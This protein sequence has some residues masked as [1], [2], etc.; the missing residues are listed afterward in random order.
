MALD[1]GNIAEQIE[2]D[3][4][5][6]DFRRNSGIYNIFSETPQARDLLAQALA[7]GPRGGFAKKVSVP[8]LNQTTLNPTDG[9]YAASYPGLEDVDLS[10]A[11]GVLTDDTMEF[12]LDKYFIG[13][14]RLPVLHELTHVAGAVLRDAKYQSDRQEMIDNVEEGFCR[15]MISSAR[16]ASV[17]AGVSTRFAL[18][19]SS[20]AA[21][22]SDLALLVGDM[23]AQNVPD[24]EEKVM[25]LHSSVKGK[26]LQWPDL[27]SSDIGMGGS[28]SFAEGEILK[29]M[30]FRLAF[31]NSISAESGLVI[32]S[33][34]A[35]I[36]NPLGF[37]IEDVKSKDTVSTYSRIWTTIGWGALGKTVAA[38]DGDAWSTAREGIVS[39]DVT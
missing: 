30:G 11:Y 34:R 26:L 22:A 20:Q 17:A 31:T 39:L 24:G 33:S 19:T 12:N 28:A 14:H 6:A 23:G 2:R 32:A 10:S 37:V 5:L 7:N 36:V 18:D 35:A 21:L 29:V 16:P 8:R 1:S 3:R 9:Y 4:V 15:D 27:I 38:A 13:T 25:I